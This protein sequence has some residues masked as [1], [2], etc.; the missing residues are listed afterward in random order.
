MSLVFSEE[1]RDRGETPVLVRFVKL[2]RANTCRMKGITQHF[3]A[4]LVANRQVDVRGV[5]VSGAT[6]LIGVF[7]GCM[8][9]LHGLLR[10]WDVAARDGVKVSLEVLRLHF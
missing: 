9:S 10:E 1:A 7:D 3:E 6:E 8:S 2:G 5:M 4:S